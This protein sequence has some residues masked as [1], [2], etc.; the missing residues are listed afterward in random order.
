[1]PF[2]RAPRGDAGGPPCL[3]LAC[4]GAAIRLP[5]TTGA[6]DGCAHGAPIA[7]YRRPQPRGKP[8]IAPARGR[9]VITD[10]EDFAIC[11][12]CGNPLEN[13]QCVCAFCGERDECECALGDAA[14]GG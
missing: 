9:A 7:A 3:L 13:C 10:E 8:F 4:I 2:Q 1:M 6:C 11:V 5:S 14:T 12:E